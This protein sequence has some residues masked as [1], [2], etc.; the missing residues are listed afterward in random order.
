MIL[1]R[2]RGIIVL[3]QFT[4]TVAIVVVSMYTFKNHVHKIIKLWMKLQIFFLGI[5]IEEVGKMDE[6]CDMVIMNHQSLLDI[7]VIEHIHNRHLA[8][9]GKKEITDLFFF[10]HIMK[11]PQMITI[12]RENK[13]GLIKLIK[14]AKD[15]LSKNRPIAIFPEGTRSQ[16]DNMLS[17]KA[18]AA[19]VA[20]K[21]NLKVQ[22]LIIINTKKILDSQKLQANPGVVKVI[23]LDP[24]QANKDTNWYKE[25]E[26]KMKEVLATHMRKEL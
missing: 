26:E 5:K 21:L 9:V 24:V 17:F 4:I 23:Y 14:E 15:R 12:D 2:I 7:I 16:G 11:A 3:I 10:G 6:S 18:G 20:N 19:M 8:W 1:T 13:T 25:T 22:P